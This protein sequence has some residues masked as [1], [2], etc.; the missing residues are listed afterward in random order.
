MR[1]AAEASWHA[2]PSW[3]G[4]II[5]I[6]FTA[7][8][9]GAGPSGSSAVHSVQLL[10]SADHQIISRYLLPEIERSPSPSVTVATME[11][12]Q[13]SLSS[14]QHKLRRIYPIVERGPAL[15]SITQDERRDQWWCG[16]GDLSWL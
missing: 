11:V 12:E 10:Q 15:V 8:A 3:S 7:A 13:L 16:R 6:P 14:F 9:P 4:L 2:E 5:C 1:S